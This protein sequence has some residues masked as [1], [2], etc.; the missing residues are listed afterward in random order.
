MVKKFKTIGILGGMGPGSS[1]AF[2]EILV[3]LPKNAKKDQDHPPFIHYSNSLIP[4]RIEYLTMGTESPIPE[5]IRSFEALRLAGADFGVM[6]CNTAHI[7]I[8]E[9]RRGTKLP[10]LSLIEET[11]KDIKERL[12]AVKK[13]GLLATKQ[14]VEYAIY[15]GPLADEGLELI[16]P[17]EKYQE[18]VTKAIF[19]K[20][21][22]IK[23]TEMEV[24]V[25]AGGWLIEAMRHLKEDKGLE[26]VILGCTEVSMVALLKTFPGVIAIDPMEV[27]ARKCLKVAGVRLE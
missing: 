16:V 5:I 11:A 6:I 27:T 8:E 13:V 20:Q 21:F 17:D 3:G 12:P 19:D 14:T 7:F 15:E 10:I 22:G 24:A 1:V 25:E 9:I 2:T 26:G 18:L 4:P 23:A